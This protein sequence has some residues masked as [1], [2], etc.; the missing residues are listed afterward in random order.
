MENVSGMVKGKFKGKFIEILKELKNTNYV[1]KCKKMNSKYYS[2]PQSR[3][4]LIF[5]G[6]RK[7]I[8]DTIEK[9]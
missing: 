9:E 7:D 6:V 3:E 1:V 5:I 8:Y 2:V 4:R